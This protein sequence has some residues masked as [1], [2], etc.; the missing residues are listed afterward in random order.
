MAVILV[1]LV[2]TGSVF[3]GEKFLIDQ[4][5]LQKTQEKYGKEAVMRLVSGKNFYLKKVG[6]ES[7]IAKKRVT[8]ML[9]LITN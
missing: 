7:P 9:T 3:T 4:N 8:R 5:V 1:G 6:R 2:I